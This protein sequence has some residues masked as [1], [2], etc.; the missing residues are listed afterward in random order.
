MSES[1]RR[2]KLWRL[3]RKRIAEAADKRDNLIT[4]HYSCESFYDRPN[5]ESPRI[6]S[7]AV[8]R[9]E[10]AQ[11]VSFS[12]HQLAEGD[13]KLSIQDIKDNYDS[14]EKKM[15]KEFYEY[16]AKNSKAIWV[17]WNM[18]DTTYGFPALA[19]RYK[20][21]GGRPIDISESH[22]I[23]LA[24]TISEIYGK[25]YIS[26]HPRLTNLIELNGISALNFLAGEDEA[27]AFEKGEFVKLHQSTL[28]KVDIFASL[29]DNT[30]SGTLKTEATKKDI[31]GNY[32]HYFIK[33]IRTHWFFTLLTL[34]GT[35]LGIIGAYSWIK[36]N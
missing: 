21:L 10:S 24:R 25:N 36:P 7:I 34:A 15:L 9:I 20:V 27:S 1:T 11:T 17:H 26:K 4:I 22:M 30:S 14:L 12:I 33:L 28:R 19:H 8:R 18:R 23:D 35:I 32:F 13:K 5:G 31:Y 2:I 3:A 29:F 6:T 16:V